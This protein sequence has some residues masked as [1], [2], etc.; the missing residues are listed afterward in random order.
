LPCNFAALTRPAPEM[1]AVV[2]G[3]CDIEALSKLEETET[4]KSVLKAIEE[5]FSELTDGVGDSDNGGE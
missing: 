1:I 3:M 2:N 5:R 4:R